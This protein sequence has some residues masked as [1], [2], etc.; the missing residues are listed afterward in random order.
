MNESKQLPTL[1]KE[2]IIN[3]FGD[4]GK[5]WLSD[6]PDL[7]ADCEA[8]FD[9]KVKKYF[10]TLSY[11]Y[12]AEAVQSDGSN[13]VIKICVP[14]KEVENEINALEFMRGDGIVKLIKADSQNGILLL[15]KLEPG[16]MLSTLSSDDEATAI[17]A[18]VMQ[19]L[20]KPIADNHDF[21]TTG[22]W[23]DRLDQPINLPDGFSGSLIDKAKNIAFD[24]HQ[25][26]GES[27][28]LHGDLHH[29][30]ILSSQ[31]QPWLAIDPKGVI[32]EREYEVGALLRNPIPDIAT[33]MDTNKILVQRTALLSEL[34]GFDRQ[35]IIA[36][37][38][39]QA[40]LAAVWSLDGKSDDWKIFLRCSD[41][42]SKITQEQ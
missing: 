15:E 7:I 28:L 17:A 30:N 9:L 19:K 39:S 33:T 8:R 13:I 18:E 1:F 42:F 16:E 38:F 24:L 5:T 12:T 40:V 27:V 21:P 29:F 11:H 20:W 34:L 23:F 36:W 22:Q 31:R 10:S 4:K 41:A 32:G 3:T 6:L 2:R 25:D 37:G 26:L 35:K 14:T